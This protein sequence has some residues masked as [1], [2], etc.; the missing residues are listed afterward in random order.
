VRAINDFVFQ[1]YPAPTK[2][3]KKKG[4]M[5][6]IPPR[7]RGFESHPLHHYVKTYR[8]FILAMY[9][10]FF[11]GFHVLGLPFSKDFCTFKFGDAFKD[12][13]N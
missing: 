1:L 6:V 7:L 3:A 5:R 2:H 9:A 11:L 10:W 4:E 8:G 13:F 12:S